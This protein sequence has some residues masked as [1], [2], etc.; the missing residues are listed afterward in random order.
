VDQRRKFKFLTPDEYDRLDFDER[1][2]YLRGSLTE[3]ARR[4]AAVKD[5]QGDLERSYAESTARVLP[6]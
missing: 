4:L 2:R 5:A 3:V 6:A 1:Q